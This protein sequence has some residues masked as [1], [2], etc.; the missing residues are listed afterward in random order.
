MVLSKEKSK[1]RKK[2]KK[3]KKKKHNWRE[4]FSYHLLK[5]RNELH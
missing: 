5:A 4:K 2:E 3:K 1:V